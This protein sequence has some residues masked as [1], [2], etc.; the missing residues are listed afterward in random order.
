MNG[1]SGISSLSGISGTTVLTGLSIAAVALALVGLVTILTGL[2]ALWRARLW[3]FTGRTLFGLLL[4]TGGILAGAI[5]LGVQGYQALTREELV[6]RVSIKPLGDQRFE[7]RFVYPDAREQTFELSGDEIYVDARILKWT[8]RANLIGLH[9]MWELD[10]VA[11]RY[12]SIDQE[13]TAPRTVHPLGD[14]Q[15]VDLFAL[16]KRFAVLAP[17]FDAEYGSAT[18]VPAAQP[19]ELELFVSTTGLLLRPKA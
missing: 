13:K 19:A 7:A 10:R 2:R 17:L 9:T 4:L 11:G 15:A 14:P 5:A 18:F 8:P 6:A 3:S 12:R 1:L 16:R